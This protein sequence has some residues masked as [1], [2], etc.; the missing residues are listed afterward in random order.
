MPRTTFAGSLLDGASN[1]LGRVAQAVAMGRQNYQDAYD[2][3]ATL[4]THMAQALA[5]RLRADAESAK[6][7]EET[8][9]LGLKNDVLAKLP[10]LATEQAAYASGS[11]VPLVN[12]VRD[13][14]RTGG[15]AFI[16]G[17]QLDGPNPDGSAG[18]PALVPQ[19]QRSRIVQALQRSLPV[20]LID[21]KMA[22]GDWAKAAETYGNMDL[23]DAVLNGT[24]T[25]ADVGRAQAAEK[26]ADLFKTGSQGQVLDLF[27]GGVNVNNPVAQAE[28][29][30]VGAKTADAN[31]SAGAHNAAAEASRAGK[32]NL[33]VV[34][35]DDGRVVVVDKSK[36]TATPAVGPD[37]KPVMGKG[38][39]LNGEQANALAFATRMQASD[40][41]LEDLAAK[42]VMLP[43]QMRRVGEAVPLVG[44]VLGAAAN[45]GASP[46]Q[47][48]FEQ[49]QRDFINAVLRRESGAAISAGEF[50]NAAQQY[51]PQPGDKK[52]V[53]EQKRAARQRAYQ[54][55]MAAVPANMRTLPSLP[56]APVAAAPAA[57]PTPAPAA[58]G[59][60][61][62]QIVRTGTDASGRKVVQYD[63]GSIGYAN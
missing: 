37:G 56:G 61:G 24:R 62:R 11:S 39:T 52:A 30:L 31:A 2:R 27:G 10:D 44:G 51:F 19:E 26:G 46:E 55:M 17:V 5:Q 50:A 38:G 25:A 18:V 12:A 20:M 53:I 42:G 49:A 6:A 9:G 22:A 33:Q 1:G 40:K 35:T 57:P 13:A 14:V 21:G 41:I 23:R 7:A 3:E 29:K 58:S 59:A 63:D 4:Q 36:A 28:L 32:P 34:T 60:G 48:Q 8:R 43:S 15:Q 45:F 47:Q 16:P 54:T